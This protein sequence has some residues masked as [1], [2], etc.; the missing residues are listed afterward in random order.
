MKKIASFLFEVLVIY[1]ALVIFS[2]FG[3][4]TIMMLVDKFVDKP[5]VERYYYNEMCNVEAR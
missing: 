5:L 2:V 4:T 1:V 3:G